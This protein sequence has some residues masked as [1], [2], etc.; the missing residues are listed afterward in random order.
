MVLLLLEHS[1]TSVLLGTAATLAVVHTLL[2]VDHSLP[3]VAIGRA[4]GWTLVKTIMVT[5]VCGAGHVAS[6][7][8]IAAGGAVVGSTLDSV[9][10]LESA[11]GELAAALLVGFGLSY[12][13][14]A[15]W[16]SRRGVTH[17]HL[18][19]HADGTVHSHP[20]AHVGEHVHPHPAGRS[21]TPWALFVIFIFG[22]CEPLIPLMVVPAAAG[23]WTVVGG[24]A[25]VFGLLTIGTMVGTVA[26]AYRGLDWFGVPAIGRHADLVAGLLVAASG[27]A[28]LV[29]GI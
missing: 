15:L 12:A 11:R 7:V 16:R 23:S 17:T 28:V 1:T 26:V 27:A 20:H 25:L 14:W 4:R 8:L 19:T 21:L 6:S 10:W 24:V 13:A 2:G 5:A 18:H 3:F 29:L 9:L 22:P